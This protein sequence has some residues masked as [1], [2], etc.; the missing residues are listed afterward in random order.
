MVLISKHNL[1]VTLLVL[2]YIVNYVNCCFQR[3]C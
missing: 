3:K 1:A 2:D